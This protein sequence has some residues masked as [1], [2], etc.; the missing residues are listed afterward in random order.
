MCER[1]IVGCR[2]LRFAEELPCRREITRVGMHRRQPL[3][4]VRAQLAHALF[5]HALE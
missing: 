2:A 5:D 4:G 3:Q 1:G